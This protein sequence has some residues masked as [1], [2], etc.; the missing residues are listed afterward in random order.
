MVKK[1]AFGEEVKSK[2]QAGV[3]TLADAVKVTLGPKGRNVIIDKNFST[4]HITKD[5][6]T[7]AQEITVDGRI[8]NI[9]VTMLKNIARKTADEAGD[10][11]STATVLAQHIF[12]EGL[13]L[14]KKDSNPIQIKREMDEAVAK[15]VSYIKDNAIP[16]ESDKHI[17]DIAK[18]SANGDEEIANLITDVIREV[19]REGVVTVEDSETH[20]TYFELV[21]GHKYDCSYVSPYFVTNTESQTAELDKPLILITNE[22]VNKFQPIQRFVEY[23]YTNNRSLLIV[24]EEMGG[25]ALHV[26]LANKQQKGLKVAVVFAPGFAGQRAALL[27]DMAV[28][29]DAKLVGDGY[30]L[31]F[32]HVTNSATV[33]GE[34]E[35]VRIDRTG[36]IILNGKA[37]E[38]KIQERI[39][40]IK[41]HRDLEPDLKVKERFS[42]RIGTLS[43]KV[44][45]IKVGGFS[46]VEVKEKKDRID[47]ALCAARAAIDE[48]II[49]GA[50][51]VYLT[52]SVLDEAI[53]DDITNDPS[54][55]AWI[56]YSAITKPFQEM[57]NNAG[58]TYESIIDYYM[59]KDE[60]N[61]HNGFDFRNETPVNLYE[62]GIIDPAKVARVALENAVS[63]AGLLLTTECVVYNKLT[64]LD[65]A[66][67][68]RGAEHNRM[69]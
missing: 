21:Q 19:S 48:G 12:K 3:D 54:D 18:V 64:D 61:I 32:H 7:V 46:E 24:C 13:K 62:A 17:Y 53:Y 6:V 2:L 22:K 42:S 40:V 39:E 37:S 49:P 30:G 25:E 60:E 4:P 43:G 67:L 11:T 14:I 68:S 52:S 55:G 41:S 23:A 34:A 10:G 31:P 26:L 16:V 69:K 27:E 50:G 45:V 20:K 33:F 47:D 35:K 5:G 38:E 15:V 44:A 36:T 63:I 1:V 65:I 28:A 51:W 56:I 57:C 8:E 29:T 66:M 59:P 58:L 9:A